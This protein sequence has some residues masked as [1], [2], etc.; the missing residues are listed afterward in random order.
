MTLRPTSAN[1]LDTKAA[2]LLALGRGDEAVKEEA[3]ALEI[4]LH[5]S[6]ENIELG[7]D[8]PMQQLSNA[9]LFRTRVKEFAQEKTQAK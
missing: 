5:N 2:V 8:N 9:Q 1:C 7:A 3:R 4:F 6:Q